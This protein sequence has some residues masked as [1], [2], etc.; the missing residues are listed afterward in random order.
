MS[1]S[2]ILPPA[3]PKATREDILA[4]CQATNHPITGPITVVSFRGY[5]ARTMGAT[6]GNDRGIYDDALFIIGPNTF[7]AFNGN[8]DPSVA[9]DNVATLQPGRYLYQPGIHGLSRPAAQQYPAF[10]QAGPVIVCRDGTE[11]TPAGHEDDSL[12]Y[13]LGNSLWTDA[14]WWPNDRFAINIH[15]GG[16]STTSSLGCQTL[17]PD[18]WDAFHSL[19]M[20][21]LKRA[22]AKTFDLVVV[23]PAA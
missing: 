4:H 16:N 6:K 17:P 11:R 13:C 2:A 1:A 5:Y 8:N 20:L 14:K 3:K 23:P 9:R 22:G 7:A 10:V 15:R 21:E 19:L 12:G 18:Q